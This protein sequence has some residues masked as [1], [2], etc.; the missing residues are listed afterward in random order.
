MLGLRLRPLDE[1][2]VYID[3]HGGWII[4]GGVVLRFLGE[5]VRA[6]AFHCYVRELSEGERSKEKRTDRPGSPLPCVVLRVDRLERV[7]IE[8]RPYLI[9]MKEKKTPIVSACS[10]AS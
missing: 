4:I 7:G 10:G 8:S 2:R 9:R 3:V 6:D 1:L 5:T